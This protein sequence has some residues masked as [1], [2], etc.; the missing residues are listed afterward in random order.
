MG[1]SI[2]LRLVSAVLLTLAPPAI[3]LGAS[4]A[5][6]RLAW[7][8]AMVALGGRV[9]HRHARHLRDRGGVDTQRGAGRGGRRGAR[10]APSARPSASRG[11]RRDGPCGASPAR[12]RRRRGARTR[13]AGRAARRVRGHPAQHDRGG[14]GD[15][16]ARRCRAGQRRGAG[17][18]RARR[19]H[20]LPGPRVRR[21]MPR[22]APAGFRR[23]L[24]ERGGG[25]R[26]GQRRVSDSEPRAA[27]SRRPTPRPCAPTPARR[28][29]GCWS[30]TTSPSSSPTRPCA[31]ISSPT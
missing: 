29:P 6:G 10:G 4:L 18:V 27:L 16:T 22:P 1:K 3:V 12:S 25:Q 8:W 5:A 21:A 9:H 20:Q 30:S 15:G 31:R 17:H 14:G 19:R 11:R 7:P 28:P 2:K 26:D 24:D 23:A 13:G